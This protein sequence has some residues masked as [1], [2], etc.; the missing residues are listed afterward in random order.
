MLVE[1]HAK[2]LEIDVRRVS[3]FCHHNPCLRG[4]WCHYA[5]GEEELGQ[6]IPNFAKLAQDLTRASNICGDWLSAGSC[7]FGDGCFKA[8][9]EEELGKVLRKRPP[10]KVDFD[11][12]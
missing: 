4:R 1:A 6:K 3:I 5:H 9:G 8:H 10:K 2:E 12:E 11:E 7:I